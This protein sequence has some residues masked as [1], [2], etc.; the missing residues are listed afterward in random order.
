LVVI[1]MKVDLEDGII[2]QLISHV[3]I[4]FNSPI[5]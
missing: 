5:L 4:H 1:F 3:L 2:F